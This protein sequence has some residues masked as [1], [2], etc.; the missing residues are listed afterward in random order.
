[1]IA[2]S[3][4]TAPY[5]TSEPGLQAPCEA[6]AWRL[7]SAARDDTRTRVPG[8]SREYACA[9]ANHEAPAHASA[10]GAQDRV[11]GGPARLR[12]AHPSCPGRDRNED[13]RG[14]PAQPRMSRSRRRPANIWRRSPAGL[15]AGLFGEPFLEHLAREANVPTDAYAWHS[16]GANRLVD[17][18]RLDRQQM[19]HLLGSPQRAID[20]ARA[21]AVADLRRDV[22][23]YY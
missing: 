2:T 12:A 11:A 17:P 5:E 20:E 3:A 22:H 1:M 6:R 23:A 14:S 15:L 18:A 4:A 8:K 21:P 13:A 9:E 7:L 16:A 10:P 19:R